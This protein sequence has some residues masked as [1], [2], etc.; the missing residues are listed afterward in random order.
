MRFL[1]IGLLFLG[2]LSAKAQENNVFTSSLKPTKIYDREEVDDMLTGKLIV[3]VGY[4]APRI[5]FGTIK[6]FFGDKIDF[7]ET[8]SGPYYF[9][10]GYGLSEYFELGFNFNLS[11]ANATFKTGNNNE[12]TATIGYTS[13]SA[14]ARLNVHFLSTENF[15]PYFGLSAGYRHFAFTY[16]DNVL[17]DLP[18]LPTGFP[19]GEIGVGARY[20]FIPN[21][22]IY[23]E[24]GIS[25]TFFQ[26]GLTVRF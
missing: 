8:A 20:F 16:T 14:L 25:R 18:S 5:S 2:A 1:L 9:K 3:S 15:S 4:G 11:S 17:P 6:Y 24:I 7:T 21:V 13:W 19:T 22:G 26:G 23:S 12:Y 10:A